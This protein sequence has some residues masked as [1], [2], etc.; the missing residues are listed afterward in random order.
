VKSD[1]FLRNSKSALLNFYTSIIVL[2][3]ATLLAYFRRGTTV[4]APKDLATLR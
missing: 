3:R 4:F 1:N 2:L